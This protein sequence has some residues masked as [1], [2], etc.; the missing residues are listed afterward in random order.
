MSDLGRAAQARRYYHHVLNG[1]TLTADDVARMV[2]T[3]ERLEASL[4]RIED[5]SNHYALNSACPEDDLR[6]AHQST[7]NLARAALDAWEQKA[8]KGEAHE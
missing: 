1:G 4:C 3:I 8:T 7:R 2:R 6:Y 5:A